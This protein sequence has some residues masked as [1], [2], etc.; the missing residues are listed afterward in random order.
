MQHIHILGDL[1]QRALVG[2]LNMD[3]ECPSHY[4][5]DTQKSVEDTQK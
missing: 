4:I 5:E 2:K 3:Q 1:G